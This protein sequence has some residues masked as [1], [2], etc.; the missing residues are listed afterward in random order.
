MAKM[1][2]SS[3]PLCLECGLCCNGV[4]FADV[5]LQPGDD[6]ARLQ[7][8]GLPIS[9]S[10][11]APRTSHFPQPCSALKGCRCRIYSDRPKYCREFDCLLLKSV[12]TGRVG[13]ADA[14]HTIRTARERAEKVRRLLRQLGDTDEHVPLATRVRRTARRLDEVGLDQETADTYGQLT[15]AFHDLSLLLSDAFYR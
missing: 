1:M 3:V 8:L 14:L 6:P 4:I 11:L 12:N 5:R 15:L 13:T 10:H 2:N 9:T 7:S